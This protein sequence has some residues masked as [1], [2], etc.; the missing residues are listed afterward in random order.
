M[1]VAHEDICCYAF[2]LYRRFLIVGRSV[3]KGKSG[4]RVAGG[5]LG[6]LGEK[7]K[8]TKKTK[9]TNWKCKNAVFYS[10]FFAWG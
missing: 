4:E 2:Y 8:K 6:G 7:T 5:G 3:L 9:N 1:M 10:V